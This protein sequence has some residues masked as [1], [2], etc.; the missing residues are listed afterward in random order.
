MSAE[1]PTIDSERQQILAAKQ[2]GLGA[3][4]STYV[5]MSGPGWLQ[6]AITLGGGSLAG[7]LYLGVL[8]GYQLMWLQLVAMVL[9]IVMLSAISY[10]TLSTGKRPFALINNQLNP[11]LGWSWAIAVMM[12]NL[13]WCLPQFALG[14]AAVQQNLIPSL[15]GD[16]GKVVIGGV[17]LVVA[18]VLIWFYDSGSRGIVLFERILKFMVAIIVMSFVGVVITLT[19]SSAGLPWGE[20]LQGFIPDLGMFNRIS[21]ELAEQVKQSSAPEF[22]QSKI[23]SE[24]RNVMVTAV[25]TAVGINMTFLLPYSMLRK[26]WDKDFRGLAI[27]DLSIGLFIPFLLATSCVVMASASQFHAKYDPA[28]IE[29]GG[30]AY[31]DNLNAFIDARLMS[32]GKQ[33]TD[34]NRALIEPS[35]KDKELAAMLIRRDASSLAMSLEPLTGATVSHFVFGLGV[36]AM[37]TSTI[38]ILMLINGFTLCEMLGRP[39]SVNIHRLGC[40][41]VGVVGF[42]GPFLWTG[43]TK[44]WLAVPTSTFGMMLLPIAYVTFFL[45]MNSRNILGADLP[46]GRRRVLWNALMLVA[47]GFACYGAYVSI[48]GK[49]DLIFGVQVRWLALGVYAVLGILG[50]LLHRTGGKGPDAPAI[51]KT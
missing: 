20:I 12:A 6:G 45:M 42:A 8:A 38:I 29:R 17:L 22:W 48:M 32:A 19:F 43:R 25:A 24:Q 35:N 44:F 39:N 5:K 41:M 28:V 47:L 26:R 14:T 3:T 46:K 4:C 11:V 40:L 2:E 31:E 18:S 30:G 50:V 7:S 13:V 10:V 34:A 27:F 51:Y 1:A 21:T 15:D 23:L 9:G 49:T 36:L 33:P 16:A 37:A